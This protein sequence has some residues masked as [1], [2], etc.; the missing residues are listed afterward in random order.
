MILPGEIHKVCQLGYPRL[1]G[2]VS[3]NPP[4]IMEP[5]WNFQSSPFVILDHP[6]VPPKKICNSQVFRAG[7]WDII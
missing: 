5:M 6:H 2:T 4:I 7:C 3:S 1:G